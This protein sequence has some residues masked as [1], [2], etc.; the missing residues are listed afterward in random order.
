MNKPTMDH[1]RTNASRSD[2]TPGVGEDGVVHRP[3]RD[4]GAPLD[5]KGKKAA[6]S[7]MLDAARALRLTAEAA[8]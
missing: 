6:Q 8:R 1:A 4:R 2:G 7:R 5:T 3:I